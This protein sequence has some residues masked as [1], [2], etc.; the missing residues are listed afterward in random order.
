VGVVT[1]VT[2]LAVAFGKSPARGACATEGL[3]L[4]KGAIRIVVIITATDEAD[5]CLIDVGENSE[6]RERIGDGVDF[7]D[8]GT[9]RDIGGN[10]SDK[11][12]RIPRNVVV[13]FMVT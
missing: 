11:A 9:D 6:V 1:G 7:V 3:R 13:K 10:E 5:A 12:C 4:T 2:T 8:N